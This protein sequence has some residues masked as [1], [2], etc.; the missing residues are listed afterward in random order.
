MFYF[1]TLGFF[2]LNNFFFIYGLKIKTYHEK[3]TVSVLKFSCDILKTKIIHP[4]LPSKK[5]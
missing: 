5:L 2:S 4:K 3:A 1:E